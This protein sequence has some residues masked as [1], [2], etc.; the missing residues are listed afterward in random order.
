IS[1]PEKMVV[2][3]VQF[4]LYDSLKLSNLG[5]SR[6]A[7]IAAIK[8]FNKLRLSGTLHNERVLSIV[9]FSVPSFKKRLFIIDIVSGRLLFNT[10]V[11]HGH[12]SGNEMATKFSNQF[13]SLQSSLGFYITGQTYRGQHGT[14]LR[15]QGMEKGINDNAFNRGIVMH[16]A[17]YVPNGNTEKLAHVGRSQGCPA[18]P[19]NIHRAIIEIIKNGTCLFVYSSDKRYL[20]QSK[21]LQKLH[22]A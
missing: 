22:E 5:L 12:N 20:A 6:D 4:R 21:Y 14:S 15:L 7:Y 10:F 8:G 13:N 9:D 3:N 17:S 11:S 2:D 19:V 1:K 18:I 16:G